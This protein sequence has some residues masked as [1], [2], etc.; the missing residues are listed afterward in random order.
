MT[1]SNGNIDCINGE[2]MRLALEIPSREAIGLTQIAPQ[3]P[4][5]HTV[6]NN[7]IMELILPESVVQMDLIFFILWL[8]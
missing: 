1:S 3:A 5:L 8:V 4:L 7:G 2:A 6:K